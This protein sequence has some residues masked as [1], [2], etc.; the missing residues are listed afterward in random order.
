MFQS[1]P[2]CYERFHRF[3]KILKDFKRFQECEEITQFNFREN[4]E[5]FKGFYKILKELR[6][7]S[8]DYK[9][10]EA[11]SMFHGFQ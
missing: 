5:F 6:M 9:E 7:I 4:L 3:K 11:V 8:A 10:F 1:I 2:K